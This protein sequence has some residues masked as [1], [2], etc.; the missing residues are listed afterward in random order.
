MRR[1]TEVIDGV[2]RE[3]SAKLVAYLVRVVGDFQLAEDVF[4][5]A[6]AAA[7]RRWPDEG[8]PLNPAGWMVRVARNAAID[9][10]RRSA[11]FAGK[12]KAVEILSRLEHEERQ[13]ASAAD[14]E[15]FPDERLRLIFTCC[16]PALAGEVQ[17]PLTLRAICGLTTP[18][19]AQAF[20]VPD[21]TMAQRLVRAKRK[22]RDAGIPYRVP[23]PEHLAER[24]EAV[25]AVLY[26]VFNEGYKHPADPAGLRG[27]AIRLAR[28]V[29]ELLPDN[30]EVLGLLALMI[31]HDA[32]S[33]GR[34]DGDGDLILLEDQ[35]R[36]I[37]RT[38]AIAEG[39]ALVD[40]ALRLARVGPYQVQAAIAALHCQAPDAART[41]WPQ[42]VGLYNLLHRMAPTDV[43]ALNRAAAVGMAMGPAAGLRAVDALAQS[44]SLASYS[45]LPAARADLL[46]RAGREAEAV[47]A[48]ERALELAD[49]ASERRYYER[50]L[51]ELRAG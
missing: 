4:H 50:R 41:D 49:D 11:N 26:L 16:H 32:R 48:Y 6:V 30:A 22:I 37:W 19:I 14:P 21:A 5:E 20:L 7:L 33:A 8:I 18:Q 1:V 9:R 27:E 17:V 25:L 40:R 51:L 29:D 24:L 34:F 43:V 15:F 3:D 46:R 28:L 36:T 44:K 31:L 13:A 12:T 39:S 47:A 23:D 2:Y 10:L 45:L 35:D 42:I 38:D